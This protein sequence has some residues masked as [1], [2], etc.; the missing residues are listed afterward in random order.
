[1]SRVFAVEGVRRTI[2]GRTVL[3]SAS[4][5]ASAGAVTVLFG[6]NGSGKS[7][8]LRFGA[9]VAG[10]DQGVVHFAGRAYTR[11]RLHRMAADGLFWLPDRGL[12]LPN[13]TIRRHLEVLEWSFGPSAGDDGVLG[14]AELLDRKP[15]TLSGGERRRAE[16]ALAIRRN[17]VCLLADEPLAGI[18]PTDQERLVAAFLALAARG[19]AVVITGH[20]VSALFAVA[21]EVVWMTAG[22]THGLRSVAQALEHEQFRREYLGIARSGGVAASL[23]RSTAATAASAEGPRRSG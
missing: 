23:S 6:R 10:A 12:L 7:T 21:D 9:G 8:L 17:P 20:D 16:V 4:V 14:L 1:M 19:C 5:W 2:G 3:K 15:G 18:A 11:P 13:R 22:T